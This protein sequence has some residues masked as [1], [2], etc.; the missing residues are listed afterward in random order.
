MPII[1]IFFV[2]GKIEFI[3]LGNQ[4]VGRNVVE[5]VVAELSLHDFDSVS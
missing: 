5:V 4:G 2:P 3:W 1:N